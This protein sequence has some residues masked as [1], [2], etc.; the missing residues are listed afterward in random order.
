MLPKKQE[1]IPSTASSPS[2]A[3]PIAK[4]SGSNT[5]E[6]LPLPRLSPPVD[7]SRNLSLQSSSKNQTTRFQ[8]TSAPRIT[9]HGLRSTADKNPANVHRTPST[10]QSVG[11]AVAISNPGAGVASQVFRTTVDVTSAVS[12]VANSTSDE[13][14]RTPDIV[15]DMFDNVDE[16]S[17]LNKEEFSHM[18]TENKSPPVIVT[19]NEGSKEQRS[20]TMEE[21]SFSNLGPSQDESHLPSPKR[22]G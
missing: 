21:Q 7:S 2:N 14:S 6:K 5:T 22:K 16:G 1:S 4:P 13:L 11:P 18:G 8:S 20:L 15:E 10:V 3:Q 19:D 9:K 12:T 17:V